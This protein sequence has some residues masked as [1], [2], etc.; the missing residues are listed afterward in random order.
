MKWEYMLTEVRIDLGGL[1]GLKDKQLIIN[2][3]NKHGEMGWEA[4]TVTEGAYVLMKRPK[5]N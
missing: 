3:L 5:S 4:V 1:G 2:E